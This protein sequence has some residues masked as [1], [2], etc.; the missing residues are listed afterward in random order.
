MPS[1][2]FVLQEARLKANLRIFEALGKQH[3][4]VW[5]YTLK[6]FHE[7]QGL[8]LIASVFSGWSVGNVEELSHTLALDKT[9]KN[10]HKHSYTH[11]F[12]HNSK[13]HAHHI[14]FAL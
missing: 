11:T 3:H 8:A 6:C 9:L 5:L 13:F 10:A 4:I 14:R 1:P 12:L 2:C 7:P